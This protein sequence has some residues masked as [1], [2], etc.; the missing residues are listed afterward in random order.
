MRDGGAAVGIPAREDE[1]A[2]AAREVV[3]FGG[4][5]GAADLDV[6]AGEQA[7]DHAAE[8]GLGARAVP[9]AEVAV[10]LAPAPADSASGRAGRPA[11][12]R[13]V[14]AVLEQLHVPEPAADGVYL[15][16]AV[17]PARPRREVLAGLHAVFD[18]RVLGVLARAPHLQVA[19]GLAGGPGGL[20]RPAVTA[21]GAAGVEAPVEDVAGILTAARVVHG[22]LVGLQAGVEARA[23]VATS[24]VAR[25]DA[26]SAGLAAGHEGDGTKDE[27]Y[28]ELRESAQHRGPLPQG[29]CRR[30][31][32][33]AISC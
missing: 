17:G 12:L 33:E 9:D 26:S 30:K 28:G 19:V 25:R 5:R 16:V 10:V 4:A 2:D 14:S 18:A 27:E 22:G 21:A 29:S 13:R 1:L 3:A 24:C 6:L 15:G 23:R 7:V 11:V 32:R 20:D 31:H 8:Q